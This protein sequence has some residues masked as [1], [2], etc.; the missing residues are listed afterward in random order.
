MLPR[1]VLWD[2]AKAPA[3]QKAMMKAI[4]RKLGRVLRTGAALR[5]NDAP[6]GSGGTIV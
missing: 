1:D 6:K 4:V 2:T 3:V 5:F